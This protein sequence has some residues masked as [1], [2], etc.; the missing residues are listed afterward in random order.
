MTRQCHCM[1]E[2]NI[3]ENWAK[4]QIYKNIAKLS[5]QEAVFQ[6]TKPL[7]AF[8]L[9]RFYIQTKLYTV[10]N[11]RS[12]FS[13]LFE[14]LSYT[15]C[16]LVII[17]CIIL[18]STLLATF[19]LR[20][21]THFL[22]QTYTYTST[23]IITPAYSLRPPMLFNHLFL[24]KRINFAF[25]TNNFIISSLLLHNRSFDICKLLLCLTNM[26]EVNGWQQYLFRYQYSLYSL[27]MQ[28]DENKILKFRIV[29]QPQHAKGFKQ[30]YLVCLEN[31]EVNITLLH[32]DCINTELYD[33]NNWLVQNVCI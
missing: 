10:W 29:C 2:E 12:M 27:K 8:N 19:F 11:R 32:L 17:I 3:F 6:C 9:L 21:I 14:F 7:I 5:T 18:P 28:I 16:F 1:Q 31:V 30:I 26:G 20:Q 4:Y 15:R 23:R 25:I 33:H 24:H 22:I 13:F